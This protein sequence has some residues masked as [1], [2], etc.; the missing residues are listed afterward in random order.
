MP[1]Q[2]TD[3]GILFFFLLLTWRNYSIPANIRK[4]NAIEKKQISRDG[5]LLVKHVLRRLILYKKCTNKIQCVYKKFN[6][7][8]TF[9]SLPIHKM[10]AVDIG[11]RYEDLCRLCA[12]KTTVLLSVNIFAQEGALRQVDKKIES[13][14][15]FQVI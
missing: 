12:M 11:S 5:L 9:S 3:G 8:T 7:L 15:Q 2:M 6:S 10:A 1:V 13:C 4:D 14:L